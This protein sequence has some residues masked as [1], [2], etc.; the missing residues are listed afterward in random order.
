MDPLSCRRKRDGI[1]G[2][3]RKILTINEGKKTRLIKGFE[4]KRW[5]VEDYLGLV[6]VKR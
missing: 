3:K 4:M 2:K 1:W 5:Y 6:E